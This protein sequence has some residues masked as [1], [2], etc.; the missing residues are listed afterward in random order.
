MFR[1]KLYSKYI[2][3]LPKNCN[4]MMTYKNSLNPMRSNSPMVMNLNL[5]LC[6]LNIS[7]SFIY[8]FIFDTRSN[9]VLLIATNFTEV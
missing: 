1:C 5:S 4:K 2:Y 3:I 9:S 6:Y 8:L 7:F